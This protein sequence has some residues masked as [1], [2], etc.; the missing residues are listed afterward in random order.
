MWIY[1]RGVT[2]SDLLSVEK[3]SVG[4]DNCVVGFKNKM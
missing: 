2:T 4:S 3:V 1:I